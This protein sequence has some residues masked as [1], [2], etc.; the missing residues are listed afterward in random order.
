MYARATS[1]D[2]LNNNKFSICS[3][4]NISQVLEKKRGN[5]FVGKCRLSEGGYVCVCVCPCPHM[6]LRTSI[7]AYAKEVWVRLSLEWTSKV[8]CSLLHLISPSCVCLCRVWPA[9][10]W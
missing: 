10:L 4:R 5:C 9:H 3:V 8:M 1:G 2:K 6:H 7:F